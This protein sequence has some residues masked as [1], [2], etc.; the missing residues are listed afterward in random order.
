LVDAAVSRETLIPFGLNPLKQVDVYDLSIWESFCAPLACLLPYI[1]PLESR[2][3]R[4]LEFT[5]VN[6]I[7]TLVYF[8]C[9]EY[10]SGR[11]L[12]EDINDPKQLPLAGLRKDGRSRGTFFEALHTRGLPQMFETCER[13]SCKAAKALGPKYLNFGSLCAL[14]GSLIDATLS[15]EWADYT[16]TTNKVKVHL[17]FD[18]NSG[19]P[20]K[21]I[22]T[23]GKGAERPQADQQ[24]EK[25]TTGI[26][27]RGYQDHQ[28]FDLWQNEGKYFV[29]R[30]RGNTKK[31]IVKELPVPE[32]T[33]LFFFAEVYL[34]DEQHRTQNTVRLVGFKV[35]KK[36]FWV[37][38]NRNDLNAQEIAF[39]YRL[40]WE[41]EKFFAWWK[42][43]LNV[44]H[45]IARSPYGLMM[46][47]LSGLITYWLI[48]IYFY[49]RY[50][51]SPSLLRLRQL[52]RDIRREQVLRSVISNYMLLIFF[53]N[54]RSIWIKQTVIVAIF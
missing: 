24:L 9:E 10:S 52:R 49:W 50:N 25:G 44:Y 38:T 42:K 23:E 39:V 29:C 12:I 54:T 28:R 21:I 8:H 37:A 35:G 15:M 43:H 32:K 30:I 31:T 26:M 4:P 20:R 46:Q 13:L 2:S 45:L 19:I 34:G 6:Q 40:R 22:L 53:T 3:N 47:L 5:F 1:L 7:Y 51:E 36:V 11:A 41:I 48:V 27:D 17:C 33:N 16:E 18:L 14:D